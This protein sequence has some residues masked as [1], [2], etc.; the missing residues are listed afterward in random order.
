M[1]VAASLHRVLRTALILFIMPTVASAAEVGRAGIGDELPLASVIPFVA[2]LLSIAVLPLAAPH[3]WEHNRNKLMV[4]AVLG[5]PLA[6]YLVG[7]YGDEGL[8]PLE[9]ASVEYLS[10]IALLGSLFVISGG[11]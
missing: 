2:L 6:V 7:M 4:S 1:I 9:H 10:F 11:I 8:V 3:W 5:A